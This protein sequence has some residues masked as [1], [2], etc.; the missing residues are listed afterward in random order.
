MIQKLSNNFRVH[1]DSNVKAHL[2]KFPY[3]SMLFGLH[4][5]TA[6]V[7]ELKALL[8]KKCFQKFSCSHIL[9]CIIARTIL[10]P[11]PHDKNNGHVFLNFWSGYTQIWEGSVV[12]FYKI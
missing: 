8:T 4:I 5:S 11:M 12:F 10:N 1:I 2:H 3:F 7:T 9:L 6:L